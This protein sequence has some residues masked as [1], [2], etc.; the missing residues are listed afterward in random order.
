MKTLI[1]AA[2]L[3]LAGCVANPGYYPAVNPWQVQMYEQNAI[4]NRWDTWRFQQNQ[5]YL[6]Q[7]QNA[8]M[9]QQRWCR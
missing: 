4:A 7:Q 2:L 3:L 8:I 6:L 5:N 9:Q 1:V